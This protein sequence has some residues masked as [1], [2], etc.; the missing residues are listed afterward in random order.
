MCAHV[1]A[2]C[3]VGEAGVV[4]AGSSDSDHRCGVDEES[5]RVWRMLGERDA[6]DWYTSRH[7][8]SGPW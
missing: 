6:V 2:I 3:G 5:C 7:S 8:R 4:H 1:V